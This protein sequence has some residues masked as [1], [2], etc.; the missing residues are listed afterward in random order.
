MA[1][2]TSAAWPRG[3]TRI[4]VKLVTR[5]SP[6]RGTLSHALWWQVP[7]NSLGGTA[8]VPQR[9]QRMPVRVPRRAD[10]RNSP[11]VRVGSLT[12]EQAHENGGRV[13]AERVDQP[14]GRA[15]NLARPGL[16]TNLGNDLRYLG[17]AGGPDRMALGLETAGGI[18]RNLATEARPAFLG[19]QPARPRLE[20]P[21][22]LCG[23]DLGDGEAVV[24]F[25]DID[26][27]R[28]LAGL[29]IGGGGGPLGGGNAREIA[30]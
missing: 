24:K 21:E 11:A 7:Q 6:D 18:D 30:L 14:G 15:A 5:P 4:T 16:A 22:P 17:G 13:A 27:G 28:A 1:Y 2:G 25:H 20:E 3:A 12:T 9:A 19:R 8:S 26:V 10:S 23:H 29:S